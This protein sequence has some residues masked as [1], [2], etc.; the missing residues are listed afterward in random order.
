[1]YVIS[2]VGAF[3]PGIVKIGTT[4]RL[5]PHDRIRELGDASVPFRYD[6]HTQLRRSPCPGTWT[7]TSVIGSHDFCGYLPSRTRAYGEI[8]L[9]LAPPIEGGARRM[10]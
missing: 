6:T 7:G 8:A 4:R 2:N 1:M 10:A 5:E 3:G 9:A